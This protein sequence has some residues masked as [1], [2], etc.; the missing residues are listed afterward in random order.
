MI[1]VTYTDFRSHV[2]RYVEAAERGE[3]VEIHRRGRPAAVL[4]AA[5]KPA[6]DYWK[7]VKPLPIKLDGVSASQMIVQ[8]R[9]ESW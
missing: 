7:Q 8:E 6:D 5:K 3:T 2:K 1:T 4:S 9:E